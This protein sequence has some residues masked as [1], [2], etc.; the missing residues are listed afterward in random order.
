MHNTKSCNKIQAPDHKAVVLDV[1]VS[2]RK[3]GKGYWK[4]NNSILNGEQY[5]LV[6]LNCIMIHLNTT[7]IMF[8]A[9][10]SGSI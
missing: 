2:N 8:H 3:R 10:S 7:V 5:K 6:L 9:C 1:Q 4:M